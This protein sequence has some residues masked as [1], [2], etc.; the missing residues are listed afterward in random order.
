MDMAPTRH[1]KYLLQL[2]T[3]EKIKAFNSIITWVGKVLSGLLEKNS[4]VLQ[5]TVINKYLIGSFNTKY[6]FYYVGNKMF[7][8]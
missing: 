4:K 6:Y 1:K 3:W 8:K 5:I 7:F 2:V